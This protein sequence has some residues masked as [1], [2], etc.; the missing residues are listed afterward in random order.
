MPTTCVI[1]S[2]G[3]AVM[4][5]VLGLGGG[6][7]MYCPVVVPGDSS[8]MFV[9]CDLGGLYRSGD[10]G[11]TWTVIDGHI[12]TAGTRCRVAFHPN[13]EAALSPSVPVT[14]YMYAPYRG[15]LRS[16]DKGVS[17]TTLRTPAQLAQ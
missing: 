11:G 6:G 2:V 13:D 3:R 9:N 5:E 15:L 16:Q 17:W 8:V 12:L 4:S 1:L 14:A 7:A 10:G